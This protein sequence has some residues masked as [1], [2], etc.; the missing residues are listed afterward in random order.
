LDLF[1]KTAADIFSL[2]KKRFSKRS[3]RKKYSRDELPLRSELFSSEQMKH[4][5]RNLAGL[6]Q[7]TRK[8]ATEKLLERLQ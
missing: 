8:K 5:G 7:L 2:L 1:Y 3:F 6:H 4:H